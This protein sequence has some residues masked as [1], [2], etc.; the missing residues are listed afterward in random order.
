MCRHQIAAVGR[1]PVAWEITVRVSVSERERLVVK[2]AVI[3][4]K[5]FDCAEFSVCPSVLAAVL[6]RVI[7]PSSLT[8]EYMAN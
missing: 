5:P 8:R 3:R 4:L 1:G 2:G 7:P 6:Y